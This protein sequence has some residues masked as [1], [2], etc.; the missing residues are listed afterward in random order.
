M[1]EGVIGH[2]ALAG[3]RPLALA[4]ELPLGSYSSTLPYLKTCPF[5]VPS[6]GMLGPFPFSWQLFLDSFTLQDGQI[7]LQLV[8]D[9]EMLGFQA[10]AVAWTSGLA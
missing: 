5:N 3:A 7:C 2:W 4:S 6:E 9:E 10:F 1:E 8:T